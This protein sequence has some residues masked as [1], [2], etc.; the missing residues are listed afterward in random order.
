MSDIPL[1]HDWHDRFGLTCC[2]VCGFVRR[3]DGTSSSCRG[4][5]RLVLRDSAGPQ[6]AAAIRA[7]TKGSPHG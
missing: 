7:L 4:P 2:R 3:G 6:D 5:V 1:A